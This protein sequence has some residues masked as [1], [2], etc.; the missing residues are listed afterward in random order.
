MEQLKY[1]VFPFNM[2]CQLIIKQFG[3]FLQH[4][5]VKPQLIPTA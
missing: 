1:R 4:K 3:V 5:R 2:I